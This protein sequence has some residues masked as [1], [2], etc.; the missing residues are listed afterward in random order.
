MN[1]PSSTITA[2]GLAGMGMSLFWEMITQFTD[3]DPRA[4]LVAISVAFVTAAVGY[5]KKE[6]VIINV[7]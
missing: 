2:A 5:G 1:K 7:D 4:T 6:N 3:M